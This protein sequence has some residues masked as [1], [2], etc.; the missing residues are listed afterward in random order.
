MIAIHACQVNSKTADELS[1][2]ISPCSAG[3]TAKLKKS[4]LFCFF[5]LH[6]AWELS[7]TVE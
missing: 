7:C 6:H 5:K 4:Y 2:H 1:H 3:M